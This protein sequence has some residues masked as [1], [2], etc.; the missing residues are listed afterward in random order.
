MALGFQLS[1]KIVAMANGLSKQKRPI[2]HQT[3]HR[4]KDKLRVEHTA[5]AQRCG[6][7]KI[8]L[9]Q[10]KFYRIQLAQEYHDSNH[11]A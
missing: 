6:Q 5:T 3:A 7:G 1:N 10:Q 9:T 8:K 4:Q 11:N 2:H